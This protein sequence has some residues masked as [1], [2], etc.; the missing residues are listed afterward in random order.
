VLTQSRSPSE[1]IQWLTNVLP[2]SR[3]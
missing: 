1:L 2:F 3:G